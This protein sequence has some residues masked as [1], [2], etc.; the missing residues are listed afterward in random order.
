MLRIVY[1]PRTK[2]ATKSSKKRDTPQ[3]EEQDN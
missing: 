2:I 1:C 3:D